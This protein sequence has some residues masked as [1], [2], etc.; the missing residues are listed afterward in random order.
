MCTITQNQ[1]MKAGSMFYALP[2]IAAQKLHSTDYVP[3]TARLACVMADHNDNIQWDTFGLSDFMRPSKDLQPSDL[4]KYPFFVF[5]ES[6][7]KRK[8]EEVNP[9]KCQLDVGS[10]LLLFLNK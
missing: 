6:C 5:L 2:L 7:A 8:V 4:I 1:V 3:N 9:G 10:D